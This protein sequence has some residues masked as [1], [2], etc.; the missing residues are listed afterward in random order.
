MSSLSLTES[1]LCAISSGCTS[2]DVARET[3]GVYRAV[4]SEAVRIRGP[5]LRCEE[6]VGRSPVSPTSSHS[7]LPSISQLWTVNIPGFLR[8]YPLLS[9][10]KVKERE[11]ELSHGLT[12]LC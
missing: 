7:L 11:E 4:R 2:V 3:E 8:V 1:Q 10:D 12:I 5:F 9:T 6:G